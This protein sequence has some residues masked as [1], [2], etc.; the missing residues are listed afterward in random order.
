VALYAGPPRPLAELAVIEAPN[1]AQAGLYAVDGGAVRASAVHVEPGAHEIW[2][3]VRVHLLEDMVQYTIDR[4]C[5]I[6]AQLE[7][8]HTYQLR[9]VK[10]YGK[11]NAAGSE[12]K[13]A[14]KLVDADTELEYH[15]SWCGKAPAL[16][17]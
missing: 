8:G 1:S 14:A 7:A 4:Y 5:G 12:V 11:R 15:A 3:H 9:V 10:E 16:D 13:V 17:G 2:S 6:A